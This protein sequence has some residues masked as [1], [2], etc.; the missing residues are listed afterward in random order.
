MAGY[1]MAL[2]K[3]PLLLSYLSIVPVNI[4]E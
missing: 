4:T 1:P 2:G 3:Q